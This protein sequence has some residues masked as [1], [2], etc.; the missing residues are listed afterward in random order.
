MARA[1]RSEVY[2]GLMGLGLS[3]M[4]AGLA[5]AALRPALSWPWLVAAWLV[6][7]NVVTFLYYG[8]DKRRAQRGGRRVP[9]VA[10]HTLAFLG[11]SL[12]A[13]AGMELFRHKTVKGTFRIFFWFVVVLQALL[14]AAVIY[15]LLQGSG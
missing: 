5:L 10:L 1:M 8:H 15:R 7:V 14:V 6:G 12:G 13:Y 3:V 2:H 9:E 11:G 4:V